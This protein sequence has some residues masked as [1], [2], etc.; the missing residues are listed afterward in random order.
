MPTTIANKLH[1]TVPGSHISAK[2]ILWA[3]LA[4][5]AVFLVLE[6]ILTPLFMGMSAWVPPRMIAAI[7]MGRSVLPPPDTFD[8]TAVSAAIVVHVV[9]S[10]AYAL[11]FA[12]VAKGRSVVADTMLGAGFGL[13]L[14]LV[15]FYGFTLWFPWFAEARHWV[16]IATH[17]AFGAVLGATYATCAQR[18]A[19]KDGHHG[20]AHG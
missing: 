10:L 13:L 17:L 12:F 18:F 15:N 14:Y 16:S 2:A 3:G 1:L 19:R 7:T 9:L 5:G 8:T 4:A 11:V 6:L 20:V